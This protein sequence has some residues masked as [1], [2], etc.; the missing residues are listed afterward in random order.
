MSARPE[1]ELDRL[2]ALW[3]ANR[4]ALVAA[5]VSY[6]DLV[7]DPARLGAALCGPVPEPPETR[8][9]L[10]AQARVADRVA[11]ADLIAETVRRGR[12]RR[13]P[14]RAV[15]EACEG[16]LPAATVR[17]GEGGLIEPWRHSAWSVSTDRRPRR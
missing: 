10:P 7:D 8:P 11:R 15:A 5:G 17:R 14:V 12:D 16:A 2:A 4:R 13:I 1:A 3:E 6:A 9:L